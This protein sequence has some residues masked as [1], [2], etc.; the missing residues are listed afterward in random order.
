MG[1]V[2]ILS[3]NPD[4]AIRQQRVAKTIDSGETWTEIDLV[5]DAG[6]REFGIGFL[7]ENQGFVGTMNSGFETNDGGESWKKIDSGRA[8][9]KIRISKRADGSNYGF[10]IGADVFKFLKNDIF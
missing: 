2:T 10:S 9:N 6:A 7:N 5:E 8:Y 3:Y 1:Y 4:P